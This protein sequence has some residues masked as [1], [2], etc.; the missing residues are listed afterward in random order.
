MPPSTIGPM[1]ANRAALSPAALGTRTKGTP[2]A[3]RAAAT[4]SMRAR[5]DFELSVSKATSR[6][7]QSRVSGRGPSADMAL[8]HAAAD[9]GR[10]EREGRDLRLEA[11][12]AMG[13]HGVA[14][15]HQAVRRG[16]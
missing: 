8:V 4:L 2:R 6:A 10:I 1:V 11:L 14:A 16:E 5:F 9:V 12:A 7:S 13:R 15:G 3:S